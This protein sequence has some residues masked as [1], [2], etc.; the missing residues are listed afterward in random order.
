VITRIS[1]RISQRSPNSNTR[2]QVISRENAC[3]WLPGWEDKA[4][5]RKCI[6]LRVKMCLGDLNTW[7][8]LKIQDITNV[9]SNWK[10]D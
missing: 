7:Y 6:H 2:F 8:L 9:K 4:L 10:Q 3:T 1:Q 5:D